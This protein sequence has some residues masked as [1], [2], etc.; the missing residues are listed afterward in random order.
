[1]DSTSAANQDTLEEYW[2]D[3][4]AFSQAAQSRA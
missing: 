3:I 1:M 2:A 4:Q